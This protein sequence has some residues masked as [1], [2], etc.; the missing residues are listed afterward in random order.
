MKFE[1]N[2]ISVSRAY[3]D[4]SLESIINTEKRVLATLVHKPVST[5]NKNICRTLVKTLDNGTRIVSTRAFI[6]LKIFFN[7]I[8]TNY[9][10]HKNITNKMDNEVLYKN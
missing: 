10:L 3:L 6:L 8:S 2:T 1:Y 9:R 4:L 7:Y 5:T